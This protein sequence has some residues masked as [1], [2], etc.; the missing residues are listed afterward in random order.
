[1]EAADG[2]TW[3]P[4]AQGTKDVPAHLT[5][6]LTPLPNPTANSSFRGP[7]LGRT[8]HADRILFVSKLCMCVYRTNLSLY[9]RISGYFYSLN[10]VFLNVL[11][12]HSITF[13]ILRKI[14][15]LSLQRAREK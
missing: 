8:Q 5:G 7:E 2:Q 11:I 14:K 1:M 13:I 3:H 6:A 9:G 12:A 15:L 4:S 10:Y